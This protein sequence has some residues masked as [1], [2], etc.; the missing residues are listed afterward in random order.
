MDK[1]K[2]EPI[3]N[4]NTK[5]LLAFLAGLLVGAIIT[6]IAIGDK[7][8][9]VDD[10]KKT[11]PNSE[12][13]IGGEISKTSEINLVTVESQLAGEIVSLKEVALVNSSWVAIHED[14]AG[15]PGNVLGATRFP[16]GIQSGTVELL[17]N[18]EPEKLYYVMIHSDDGDDEFNLKNDVALVDINGEV[19]LSAFQTIRFDRKTN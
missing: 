5:I 2:T 18:T 10:E 15:V 14:N 13:I 11:L 1:N 8:A 17:R 12:I 4:Q 3:K 19:I 16:A 9:V 7:S 6:P